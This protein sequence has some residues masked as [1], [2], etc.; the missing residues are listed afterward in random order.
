MT[1]IRPKI[2]ILGHARHGK[3]TV[4]EWLAKKGYKFV[5]SSRF[6]GE[7]AVWPVINASCRDGIYDNFEAAFNDRHN[8]RKFWYDV[9]SIYNTPDRS[10]LGR[11]ILTEN[12]LYVGL[13]NAAELQALKLHKAYDL[14]IWIDAGERCPLEPRTSITVEPWMA[15]VVIDNN[16]TLED[17]DKQMEILYNAWIA[18]WER[19]LTYCQGTHDAIEALNLK[20]QL[21]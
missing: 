9:I 16:G 5:S 15:D 4:G 10:R 18:P 3:D 19:F 12:D 21:P 8:H 17:L 6:A 20:A 14:A 11:E 1:T 13:R 7:R 2:V